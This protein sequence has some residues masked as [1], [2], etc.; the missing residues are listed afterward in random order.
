MILDW[1]KHDDSVRQFM[2]FYQLKNQSA[3]ENFL[4]KILEN[5]A[6]LPYEN[7]SKI[8]KWNENFKE[9]H[10]RLPEEVISE[11]VD[12]NFGGT[13]FSLTFYLQTIL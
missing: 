4:V 10:L 6:N 12:F 11:H 13:C 8:I 1:Q 5:F 7:I 2:N 3:G 9:N